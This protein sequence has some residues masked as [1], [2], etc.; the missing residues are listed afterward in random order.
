M[1]TDALI[2]LISPFSPLSLVAGAGISIPSTT[3]DLLGLG[4]G[5]S[6]ALAGTIIGTTYN[7]QFGT[8][9]GIGDDKVLM[10]VVIGTALVTANGATL[11]LAMQGAPDTGLTGG[12]LPGTWQT[13]LE[14]GPLTAAQCYAQAR[15]ARWDW[16]PAFPENQPPP[17]FIRLLAQ[18]PAAENFSAGT[19]AF[20]LPT[21]A[22]DDMAQRYAARGYSVS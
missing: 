2:T 9:F 5:V 14:T 6:P 12:W 16:P 19:I 22:R 3:L 8:D 11:N 17:R 21:L 18:I 1:R 7:Q 13:L 4:V 20:A 15:I 10:D